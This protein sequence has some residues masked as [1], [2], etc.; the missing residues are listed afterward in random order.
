MASQG[1]NTMDNTTRTILAPAKTTT[2]TTTTTNTT[3]TGTT[4]TTITTI[5][6]TTTI[7]PGSDDVDGSTIEAPSTGSP[8]SEVDLRVQNNPFDFV[9][10]APTP[11]LPAGSG[12][13]PPTTNPGTRTAGLSGFGFGPIIRGRGTGCGRGN[14]GRGSFAGITRRND[15]HYV[16]PVAP[17]A[18]RATLPGFMPGGGID[19]T[20][21]A[22]RRPGSVQLTGD[23]ERDRRAIQRGW[24]EVGAGYHFIT[25]RSIPQSARAG[26]RQMELERSLMYTEE[27]MARRKR[28]RTSGQIVD[29][30]KDAATVD[31]ANDD[32][33]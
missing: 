32:S 24:N 9:A 13:N 4:I 12:N 15:Q 31:Q 27:Q 22:N 33:P 11:A 20:D 8:G 5:T 16:A 1:D 26:T 28:L 14:S 21:T 23:I 19:T 10:P 30:P 6:T 29:V 18:D 2:T 25:I 3:T 7:N 17:A